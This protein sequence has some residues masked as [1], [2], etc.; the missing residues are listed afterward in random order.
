MDDSQKRLCVT[1]AGLGLFMG[2]WGYWSSKMQSQIKRDKEHELAYSNSIL[3]LPFTNSVGTP[4]YIQKRH[5][6]SNEVPIAEYYYRESD[7]TNDVFMP[8]V[9]Y[10]NSI[11]ND[12]MRFYESN[13]IL[14][15]F[16]K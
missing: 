7:K 6:Y 3:E 13:T 4:Y 9:V 12:D 14:E 11:K 1:L 5:S 15:M 8:L 2:A 16:N 10:L